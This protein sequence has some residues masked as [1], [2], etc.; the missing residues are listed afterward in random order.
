MILLSGCEGVSFDAPNG[1]C[2]PVMEYS[3]TEQAQVAGEIAAL[4]ENARIVNW[5]ADY[6]LLRDQARACR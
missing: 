6:A 1:A 3:R 4:R 2:P 5:L